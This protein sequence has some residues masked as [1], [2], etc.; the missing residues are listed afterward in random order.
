MVVVVVT[1]WYCLFYIDWTIPVRHTHTTLEP[2]CG[3]EASQDFVVVVESKQGE[4]GGSTC[5]G[6]LV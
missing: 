3:G 2:Q 4:K 1:V 5:E 6:A